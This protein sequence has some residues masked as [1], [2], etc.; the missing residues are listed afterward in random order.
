MLCTDC[1]AERHRAFLASR[2]TQE[3]SAN[4]VIEANPSVN[5]LICFVQQK[6]TVMP[7]DHL[8][9]LCS[10]FY[11]SDEIKT[12]LSSVMKFA[13]QRV[14]AYKGNDKDKKAVSDIVKIC[15]DPNVRIPTF[16][17][18]Q[19]DRLPPVDVNHVDV[20]ALLQELSSLRQDVK[21]ACQLR[22]EITELRNSVEL[23][24]TRDLSSTDVISVL[25]N[26]DFPPLPQPMH[27]SVS[28][29]DCTVPSFS[30]LAA[31]LRQNGLSAQRQKPVKSNPRKTRPAVIGSSTSNNCVKA[32][33]TSRVVDVFISRLHPLTTVNE[34]KECVTTISD[35]KLHVTEILCD[36]LKA[37]F[38]DLYAS[39][40]VQIRVNSVDM[41]GAIDLFMANESWPMGAFVRRYYRS[42]QQHDGS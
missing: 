1:D 33:T 11:N 32:V 23:L 41:K 20:S 2:S 29:D 34:V 17:A 14:P 21:A 3:L 19:L 10:S 35:G 9:D 7:F 4:T 22:A 6:S 13:K 31:D 42:T 15:L 8:V 18:L 27:V 24:K 28:T 26:A 37:R 16:C 30:S 25:R 12:A 38:E 5:E 39:F 36:K 40:R